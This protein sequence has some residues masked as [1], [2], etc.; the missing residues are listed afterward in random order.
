VI[1]AYAVCEPA[2]AAASL[3][4]RGLGGATLRAIE[5]GGVAGVYSRHRALDPHP[6]RDMV[7]DHERVV[8]AIMA[9]GAVLPVRFGT[10]VA[11]EDRLA[12]VLTERGDELLRSLARVRGRTELGVRV[13]PELPGPAGGAV[14]PSGRDY[15]LTRVREHRRSEQLIREVHEPLSALSRAGVVRRPATPPALLVAAYLVDLERVAEF[16]RRAVHLAR[17]QPGARIT[18]TGPW[19][20]Y[21]FAND[22]PG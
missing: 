1:H 17:G 8:E 6:T 12:A 19:P 22:E 4:R 7:L 9:H 21:T 18:V 20:P 13:T 2:T 16:R 3:R 15:L 5:S 10:R 14:A 11:D